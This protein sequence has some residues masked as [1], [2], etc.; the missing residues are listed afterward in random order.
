MLYSGG[1]I[2]TVMGENMD[3]VANPVLVMVQ[4]DSSAPT[5]YTSVGTKT[6]EIL[7]PSLLL[8]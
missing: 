6:V 5:T 1:T 3:T 7:I 4:E 2:L 8:Q